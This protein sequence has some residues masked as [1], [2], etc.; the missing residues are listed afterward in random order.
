M[1]FNW[2]MVSGFCATTGAVFANVVM[3]AY[4]GKLNKGRKNKMG[5]KKNF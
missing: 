2:G 4:M 1:A 3:P 5:Y